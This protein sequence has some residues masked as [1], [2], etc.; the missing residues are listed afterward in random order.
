M[1]IIPC[2]N[3]AQSVGLVAKQ[4]LLYTERVLVIDD[5]STDGSAEMASMVGAEVISM[6]RNMGV[7][8]ALKKGLEQALIWGYDTAVILDADGAHDP[9]DIPK[10][11]TTHKEKNAILTIGNRWEYV[12]EPYTIPT[13]KWWANIFAIHLVNKIAKTKSLFDVAS[14]FRVL[15][16]SMLEMPTF[17][18]DFGYMY[19]MVFY[20]IKHGNIE[21]T[22]IKVRYNARELLATKRAE[23]VNLLKAC[24]RW[25]DDLS[26][27]SQ[28]D[29][30]VIQTNLL[31]MFS[32]LLNKDDNKS[33]QL[34]V[35]P[36]AEYQSYIF[37]AQDQYLKNVLS[38]NLP[39]AS[40]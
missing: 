1:V 2:Y 16:K 22:P 15:G 28:I 38:D 3:C 34:I 37:Q 14:G 13:S 8:G 40:F 12:Y 32:V 33:L 36:V 21:Y 4:C 29:L 7:G 26:V 9:N 11:L 25:S 5:G 30:L 24:L 6:S 23:L 10:L 20:G 27:N 19:D 18:S 35:H 17:S 31:K 39:M